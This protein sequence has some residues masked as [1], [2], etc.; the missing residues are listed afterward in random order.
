VLSFPPP[1]GALIPFTIL[2]SLAALP[3]TIGTIGVFIAL[4]DGAQARLVECI[5]DRSGKNGQI[6]LVLG[7][8]DGRWSPLDKPR[9]TQPA[10]PR[11]DTLSLYDQWIASDH[12]DSAPPLATAQS[13][14]T[15]PTVQD[16]AYE[17]QRMIRALKSF[18][19]MRTA[20]SFA[21]HVRI[22]CHSQTQ[23]FPLM[24]SLGTVED[25]EVS[26]ND[27]LHTEP[28]TRQ[29]EADRQFKLQVWRT[30]I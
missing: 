19:A 15:R 4:N 7:R 16:L 20:S 12:G 27:L 30:I 17:R 11:G 28:P 9:Q 25:L 24:P 14:S 18:E 2:D 5:W 8:N 6:A 1:T 10:K 26:Y 22:Y 29:Q 21:A 3:R 23:A 13:V